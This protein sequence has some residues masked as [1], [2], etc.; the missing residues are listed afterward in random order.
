MRARY[1]QKPYSHDDLAKA[2]R[3]S[4]NKADDTNTVL[5]PL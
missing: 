5:A 2:I 3:E 4:L 1:L